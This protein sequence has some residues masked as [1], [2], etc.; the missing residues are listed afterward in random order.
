M[1][2]LIFYCSIA[3]ILAACSPKLTKEYFT[4]ADLKEV[5]ETETPAQI[6]ANK[7]PKK[8]VNG[9]CQKRVSYVPDTTHLEWMP[10]KRIR[11]NFHF[12]NSADSTQNFTEQ[13]GTKYVKHLL[14]RARELYENNQ[15]MFLHPSDKETPVLPVM[16]EYVLTP[17]ESDPKDDGIYFHYDD[18]L[19]FVVKKGKNR[20]LHSKAASKKYGIGLDSIQNIFFMPHHP[21]SLK[22]EQYKGRNCGIALRDMV[23]ITG[24]F[25]LDASAWKMGSMLN[26]EIGHN[27]GLSHEW[28]KNDGC[29]DTP[30]NPKCYNKN[31]GDGCDSL[32]SNNFMGYNLYENAWTPEQIGRIHSYI[33]RK[34]GRGRKF[35]IPEWCQLQEELSVVISE[36]TVWSGEKDLYGH[37]T[38]KTGASLEIMCRVSL[39]KNAKIVVE[40]GAKLILNRAQLHN[41]CGE[42]W[43]G[44]EVQKRGKIAGE[45]INIGEV[46]IENATNWMRENPTQ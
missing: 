25:C 12:M 10:K 9:C 29:D 2:K 36:N 42:E 34:K 32:A 5:K 40:P 4:L 26:H 35:V 15:C 31:Q 23:K 17:Q 8:S 30:P 19:Y 21:D 39:P 44:I 24:A 7:F 28:I 18:D 20:N 1:K 6:A 16:Y 14:S 22:S 43:Q 11:V 33:S 3:A 41:D 13:E 45:V 27:Y 37:L 46:K 38:I